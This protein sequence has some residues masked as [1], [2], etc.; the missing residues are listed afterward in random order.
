MR[1]IT[2]KVVPEPERN[3]RSIIRAKKAD[4]TVIFVGNES[5]TYLC[6]VCDAVLSRGLDLK[7][8]FAPPA[9]ALSCNR[10]GS[11]NDVP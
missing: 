2:M 1:K 9:P 10:C 8:R 11:C 6:G 5:V 3:T 4:S 7:R